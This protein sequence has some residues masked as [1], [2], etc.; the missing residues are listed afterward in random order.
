MWFVVVLGVL[1]LT[2]SWYRLGAR[3]ATPYDCCGCGSLR[4]PSI[5]L[6]RNATDTTLADVFDESSFTNSVLRTCETVYSAR[7][8]EVQLTAGLGGVLLAGGGV[9]AVRRRAS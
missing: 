9:L 7:A 8:S 5:G 3:L 1:L 2:L 6:A 4:S